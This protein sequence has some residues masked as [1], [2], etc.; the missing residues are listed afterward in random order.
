MTATRNP[1]ISTLKSKTAESAGALPLDH[2]P[3]SEWWRLLSSPDRAESAVFRLK[4][5]GATFSLRFR[6]LETKALKRLIE[7]ELWGDLFAMMVR[8]LVS[9][10]ELWGWDAVFA[11]AQVQDIIARHGQN[12]A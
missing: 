9:G 6:Q 1:L 10:R 11:P 5:S 4:H 7:E 12:G 2:S 3:Y 8:A